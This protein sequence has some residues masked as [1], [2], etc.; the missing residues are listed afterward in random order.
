MKNV[1][2]KRVSETSVLP[3]YGTEKSAGL[4]LYADVIYSGYGEGFITIKPHETV[5]VSTGIAVQPPEGYFG[6]LFARSGT[7]MKKGLAPAN[8]VGVIDED[9]RGIIGVALHNHSDEVQTVQHKERIAQIIFI[10]YEQFNINETDTL[11]D[12]ER[13]TGGFGSTGK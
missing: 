3:T 2:V 1:K 10:P 7:A 11:D 6:L 13:G 4:D 5:M 9:Y 8:K 12:T